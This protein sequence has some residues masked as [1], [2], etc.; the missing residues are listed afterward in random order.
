MEKFK[1]EFCDT[2]FVQK[3]HLERH[4]KSAKYCL[5]LQGE[6]TEEKLTKCRF[7]EE[8]FKRKDMYKRH[9]KVHGQDNIKLIEQEEEIEKLKNK[10][11]YLEAQIDLYKK[12]KNVRVVNNINI[13]NTKLNNVHITKIQPFTVKLLRESL[14]P[15]YTKD[16]FM[17]KLEGI[18]WLVL[19]F[20]TLDVDG[21][22]E[23]NLVCTD[24]KRSVCHLLDVD[25]NWKHDDG[26]NIC[27]K[28]IKVFIPKMDEIMDRFRTKQ[29]HYST[30]K[31][32]LGEKKTLASMTA[33]SKFDKYFD[34][35]KDINEGFYEHIITQKSDPEGYLKFVQKF[36]DMLKPRIHI[37][38][39]ETN[40]DEDFEF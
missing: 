18:M 31:N 26:I 3:V 15:Q 6:I 27:S 39:N 1:C 16:V 19:K 4:K 10:I 30:M 33:R 2:E 35:I 34:R 5:S 14:L 25:R 32:Q 8:T 23:R 24:K 20:V 13:T 37:K 17:N 38:D 9:L 29:S 7:C 40:S 12:T 11:I 36:R 21:N 22:I 28:I